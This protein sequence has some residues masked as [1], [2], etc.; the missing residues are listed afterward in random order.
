V[1]AYII[2]NAVAV[3]PKPNGLGSE[4]AN[5]LAPHIAQLFNLLYDKACIPA[6]WKQAK[7][8]PGDF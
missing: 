3:R 6:C 8:S 4:R 7:L 1:A 5:G 2:K